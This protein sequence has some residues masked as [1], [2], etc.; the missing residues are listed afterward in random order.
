M[1]IS[2]LPHIAAAVTDAGKTLSMIPHLL[3]LSLLPAAPVLAIDTLQSV[4]DQYQLNAASYNLSFPSTMLNSDAAAAWVV[5]NWNTVVNHLDW[6]DSN[7]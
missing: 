7:M 1:G 5:Q 2:H 3:V 4:I 6:G